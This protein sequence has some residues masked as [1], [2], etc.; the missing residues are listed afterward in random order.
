M[1]HR[2]NDFLRRFFLNPELG[3]LMCELEGID[4]IRMWHDQALIKEPWG[5]PTAWHLDNPYWS[6]TSRHAISIWIALDDATFQN[7]CLY[8]MPG[9]HREAEHERNVGITQD[10][11]GLFRAY[12]EW[13]GRQPVAAPM[14]AGSCS[15]HNGLTAHG[16]GA[17]CTPG[18]RRAMTCGYMP[19]GC[20]YNGKTNVLPPSYHQKLKVGDRLDS[21]QQNPLLWRRPA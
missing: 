6:F 18:R 1:L 4:G 13:A 21:D 7:G 2:L 8:F 12:P 19:D 11:G 5:N 15:F 9:S 14:K 20:T 17:N 16:A 3:R 10:F